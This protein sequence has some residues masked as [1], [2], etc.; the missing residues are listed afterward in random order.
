MYQ[1]GH[2]NGAVIIWSL[3]GHIERIALLWWPCKLICNDHRRID[4]HKTIR[5][6]VSIGSDNA[7]SAF[8]KRPSFSSWIWLKGLS[9]LDFCSYIAHKCNGLFL[10]KLQLSYGD[11]G[12]KFYYNKNSCFLKIWKKRACRLNTYYAA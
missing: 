11:T 5:H 3:R 12:I 1:V 4:L 9:I 6:L 7:P 8:L 10:Q 2:L